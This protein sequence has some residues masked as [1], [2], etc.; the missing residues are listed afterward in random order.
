MRS[1]NLLLCSLLSVGIGLLAGSAPARA[2][3][4]FT[5]D[6]VHSSLVFRVKHLDIGYIYGRFNQ[7]SGSFAFDDKN[8]ADCKLEVEVKIDSID[9][10]NGDRDKHL[11][12]PISSTPRSSRR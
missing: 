8:P 5:V 7:Y 11:K 10:A 12:G 3:D 9:S 6:P 2:T 1:H 4:T